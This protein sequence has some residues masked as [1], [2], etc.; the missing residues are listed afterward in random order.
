[1][2]SVNVQYH[3]VG[4]LLLESGEVLPETIIAYETWGSL[5]ASGD[6]AILILHALTGDSHVACG[7]NRP[8][9]LANHPPG[10]E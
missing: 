9:T 8:A 5:N 3:K 1:M 10:H 7:A 6:N 2:V 4:D